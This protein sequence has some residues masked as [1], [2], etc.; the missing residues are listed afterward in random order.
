MKNENYFKAL[1]IFECY[2]RS[3]KKNTTAESKSRS[4]L[5]TW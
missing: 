2:I 3:N 4:I 5:N 1:K